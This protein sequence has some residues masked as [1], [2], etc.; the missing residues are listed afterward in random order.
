MG[1]PRT[2]PWVGDLAGLVEFAT[3]GIV[4]KTIVDE[5]RVKV[6]LFAFSAGQTLSEH[7]AGTP[8]SIHILQGRA[9]VLLGEDRHDAGPGT[10]IYMPAHLKHAVD[11]LDDMVFLLHLHRGE[12]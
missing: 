10:Y 9:S 7:T 4:S 1:N 5:P 6:V 12:A 11:A 2:D 3:D 8:A